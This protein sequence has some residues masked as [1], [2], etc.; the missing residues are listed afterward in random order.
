[1]Q[2]NISI[3]FALDTSSVFTAKILNDSSTRK[4][5]SIKNTPQK[6][7]TRMYHAHMVKL[8]KYKLTQIVKTFRTLQVIST[9]ALKKN[10]NKI[11]KII[12]HTQ[13][14]N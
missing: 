6:G 4:K 11:H 7:T 9:N 8:T 10:M 13:K 1:M 2:L 5:A 3:Q 12:I 14:G